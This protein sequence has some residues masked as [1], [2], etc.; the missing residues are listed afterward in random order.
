MGQGTVLCQA[1]SYSRHTVNI[2]ATL[3]DV[4]APL[5]RRVEESLSF[6]DVTS[7]E[8]CQRKTCR[9]VEK[10]WGGGI[11]LYF[12]LCVCGVCVCK[13]LW[14]VCC[15]ICRHACMNMCL[16]PR[17]SYWEPPS[18]TPYL[19]QHGFSLNPEL[20]NS[21]T[22]IASMPTIPVSAFQW[23]EFMGPCC[24][25][26]PNCRW[27]IRGRNMVYQEETQHMIL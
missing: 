2:H 6:I 23:L 12:S 16:E 19:L 15:H 25:T 9:Y 13:S 8:G 5:C 22:L 10:R 14:C 11:S 18:I 7:L 21:A 26:H 17:G 1:P 4:T 3:S 27:L 20:T 24:H